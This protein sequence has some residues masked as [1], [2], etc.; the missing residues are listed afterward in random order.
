MTAV[1]G[2]SAGVADAL[3]QEQIYYIP[4][5]IYHRRYTIYYILYNIWNI[6]CSNIYIYIYI[7][8]IVYQEQPG[9]TISEAEVAIGGITLARPAAGEVS[10]IPRMWLLHSLKQMPCS[11][12]GVL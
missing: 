5:T 1:W 11:S 9:V 12:N 2:L 3:L 4:H 6:V 8:T 7:Y 10:G